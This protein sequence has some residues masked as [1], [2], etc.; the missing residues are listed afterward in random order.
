MAEERQ[1]VVFSL[2]SEDYGIDIYKVQEI[3]QYR[4]ITFVP[5]APPFVKGVIN[6]R[7]KII[8]VIDLKERFNLQEK[9][10]TSDTR[11]IVVE[12]SSQ[13]VGLIVDSVTEVLRIPKDNI[14]P[15]PPVTTIGADFIEGVGKLDERLIIILDI[16]KILTREEKGELVTLQ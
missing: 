7:G 13:T 6:L 10:I 14:E 9:E 12:I 8:P 2:L 1:L 3:I 16:D 5:K 11:I 15:P 4:D